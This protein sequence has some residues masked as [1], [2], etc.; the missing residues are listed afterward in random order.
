MATWEKCSLSVSND[1][2]EVLD[3]WFGELRPEQWFKRD[4]VVDNAVRRRFKTLHE[5]IARLEGKS[6]GDTPERS[7][8]AVIV[9]DQLS[10]NLFRD[11]ARAF[12]SDHAALA[13][14][15]AAIERGF[16][17]RLDGQR[18]VFLYMPFQ[19]SEEPEEQA[20]SVELF[21]TLDDPHSLR[22]A[23]RHK[24]IVDRFGRF[25]HRNRIL[26]RVS[27]PEELAFLDEP[28]SSF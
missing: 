23:E 8:A 15:K 19:H 1:I 5:R 24:Q 17:R 13:L 3:F 12:A 7:L 10:R 18:R 11:D 16:D 4:P 27:S 14:A 28:D 9:L 2:E 6:W 20:R 21:S 25:P 22:F 26:G